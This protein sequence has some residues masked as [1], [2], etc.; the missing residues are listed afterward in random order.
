MANV[1]STAGPKITEA[2]QGLGQWFYGGS[3]IQ[4]KTW[5]RWG[6]SY[7]QWR[8][9]RQRSQAKGGA[10]AQSMTGVH[11]VRWG[12]LGEAGEGGMEW[13][14]RVIHYITLHYKTRAERA[15]Q[16][17][18]VENKFCESQDPWWDRL[19]WRE[20]WRKSG[21]SR[22]QVLN[23]CLHF[24]SEVA[25]SQGRKGNNCKVLF[26]Y[27]FIYQIVL[28]HLPWAGHQA[29]L[30][31]FGNKIGM[32]INTFFSSFR[33]SEGVFLPRSLSLHPRLPLSPALYSLSSHCH[34]VLA[35][36]S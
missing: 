32:K 8:A 1:I 12:P 2:E 13:W 3:G 17:Q 28:G 23:I 35:C 9:R 22:S 11:L 25:G 16:N 20:G 31:P 33:A 21:V 34:P 26:H 5:K 36:V 19:R 24:G 4:V 27:S 18:K 6:G 30:N 15:L 7:A 29:S 10:G 14:K